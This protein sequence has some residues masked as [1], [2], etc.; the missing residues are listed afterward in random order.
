MKKIIICGSISSSD[1]IL[2]VKSELE[3]KGFEVEIPEGVKHLKEWEGDA[4]AAS[5]KAERK[6]KHN[7][8]RGYYEKMK[9]YDSV[10]IV[11]PEKKGIQGYIGGNTLIEMAFAHILNKSLFVL[12]PLPEMSYT[13]EI[14]AMQPTVLNGDLNK[15]QHE[16]E[17]SN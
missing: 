1:D 14:L 15:L 6:I 13:S 3:Q 10:L 11:N 9:E 16:A 8:I 7:L 2:R 12:Y 4:A 17:S 5:E